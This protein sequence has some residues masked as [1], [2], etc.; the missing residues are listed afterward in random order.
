L[1]QA[2]TNSVTS[3]MAAGVTDNRQ[4]VYNQTWNVN[5]NSLNSGREGM[6]ALAFAGG[7]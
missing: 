2:V 7:I 1:G 6:A 4:N 3:G 5:T